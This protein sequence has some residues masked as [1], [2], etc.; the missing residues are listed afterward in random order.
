MGSPRDLMPARL[1]GLDM[2]RFGE[3]VLSHQEKYTSKFTHGDL[4]PRNVIL[5]KG[6]VAAII[7]WDG[8]DGALNIGSSPKPISH[9]WAHPRNR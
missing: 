1:D 8:G 6:K 2:G 5:S 7:D 4:V 9:L 3:V